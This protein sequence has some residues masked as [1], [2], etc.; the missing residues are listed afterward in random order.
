M[1]RIE[2][3]DLIQSLKAATA[4]NVVF[5]N[6]FYQTFDRR[7]AGANLRINN[8]EQLHYQG[9]I[10]GSEFETYAATKLYMVLKIDIMYGVLNAAVPYIQFNDSANASMFTVFNAGI[11]Y[12]AAAVNYIGNLF[13][14]QNFYFSRMLPTGYSRMIFTGYRVTLN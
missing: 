11:V 6:W 4:E 5:I 12:N 14:L 7:V 3:E 1:A 10:G 2:K 8:V 9:A 13:T